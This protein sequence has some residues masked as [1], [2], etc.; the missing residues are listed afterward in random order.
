MNG[1]DQYDKTNYLALKNI[2]VGLWNYYL[3]PYHF[4]P[5]FPFIDYWDYT[6]P[7]LEA[8][9]ENDG[10]TG[11]FTSFPICLLGLFGPYYVLKMQ[12][13]YSR[14][15]VGLFGLFVSTWTVIITLFYASFCGIA[16]R[17]E[18]ELQWPL[19]LLFSL[20]LLAR[21]HV[22]GPFKTWELLVLSLLIFYSCLMGLVYCLIGPW[23]W[24]ENYLG[25]G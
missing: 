1:V 4:V 20:T 2:P 19:L 7:F 14:T 13:A 23:H 6:P 22:F 21:Y 5:G 15:V 12:D 16:F 3:L 24:I 17:Y 18:A 11:L 9:K 10:H 25:H 8:L